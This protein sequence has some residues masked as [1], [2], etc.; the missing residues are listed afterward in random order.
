MSHS[1]YVTVDFVAFRSNPTT[2]R[3]FFITGN[4]SLH[5]V[6]TKSPPFYLGASL[7]VVTE[8]RCNI[9]K[10]NTRESQCISK[11][12]KVSIIFN[13]YPFNSLANTTYNNVIVLI[14]IVS[15]YDFGPF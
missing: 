4:T 14:D 9:H 6:S 5:T 12:S 1:E 8:R 15:Y 10:K 11:Q 7:L 2:E 3:A 13:Y